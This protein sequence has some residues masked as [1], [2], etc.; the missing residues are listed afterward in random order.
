MKGKQGRGQT[1]RE[2][3]CL[4]KPERFSNTWCL[5]MSWKN[6]GGHILPQLPNLSSVFSMVQWLGSWSG[7]Q[8]SWFSTRRPRFDSGYRLSGQDCCLTARR[9]WVQILSMPGLPLFAWVSS[10]HH[11]NVQYIRVILLSV[12]LTTGKK[13]LDHWSL[14]AAPRLPDGSNAEDKFCFNI[15]EC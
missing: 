15:C 3:A 2:A 4:H 8:D 10:R 14:D 13:N 7:G 1:E 12:P 11:R 6:G 5:S 9:F